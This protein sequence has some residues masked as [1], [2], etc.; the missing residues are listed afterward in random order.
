MQKRHFST[1]TEKWRSFK[2]ALFL[3]FEVV[4]AVEFLHA[5]GCVDNLLLASVEGMADVA[6]INVHFTLGGLGLKGVP[7]GALDGYLFVLGVY[8]L[9]HLS[10]S[11]W[12]FNY[13]T[14]C[15]CF[16]LCFFVNSYFLLDSNALKMRLE[17]ELH[18]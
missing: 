4:F 18:L 3:F 16:S 7:A 8:S 1:E 17:Y 5:S 14:I 2:V 13:L 11:S 10:V 15:Q 9:F 12:G 6:D